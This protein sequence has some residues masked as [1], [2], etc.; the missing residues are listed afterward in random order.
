MSRC[1][2]DIVQQ[3]VGLVFGRISNE[4]SKSGSSRKEY[5]SSGIALT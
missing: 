1:V 2:V 3:S 5:S 4:D